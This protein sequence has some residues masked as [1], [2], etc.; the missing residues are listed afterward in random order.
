VTAPGRVGIFD[1]DLRAHLRPTD[2]ELAVLD[3]YGVPV[4]G[5]EQ[6]EVAGLV[7]GEMPGRGTR[8]ELPMLPC[9]ATSAGGRLMIMSGLPSAEYVGRL[10]RINVYERH[11]AWSARLARGEALAQVR[12]PRT[13]PGR[14]VLCGRRVLDV[15]DPGRPFWEPFVL[16]HGRWYV[17][18][19]HPS[20]RSRVYNDRAERDRVRR[21]LRWAAGV[22]PGW[23]E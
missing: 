7:V 14:V 21:V 10:G 1:R 20:G 4:E 16:E 5:W 13:L 18:A 12:L 2:S 9:P 17:G 19:P 22:E 8:P 23:W 11:G 15:F 6:Y 3:L